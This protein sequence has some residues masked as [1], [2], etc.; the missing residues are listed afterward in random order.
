M[1][2]FRYKAARSDGQVTEGILQAADPQ[3]SPA[4]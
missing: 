2:A 1:Q 3:E 4:L